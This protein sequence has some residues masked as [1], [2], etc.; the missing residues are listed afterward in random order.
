MDTNKYAVATAS[1]RFQSVWQNVNLSWEQIL[2]KLG[3]TV[4]T[5]ETLGQF[6]NMPK[7]EQDNIKDVGG[8]V[9]GYLKD[10]RR[11]TGF[12]KN[13]SL[14][15]LDADFAAEDFVGGVRMFADYTWCVYSTHKHTSEKP[16]LRLVIPLSR[17]VDCDE[18]EAIA[19]K[20]AEEIGIEQFDDTTYQSH[21]L[22][23]WPSTSIDGE[24]VFEHE[25]SKP[26][27]ADKYLEK[28]NDW[29]D[30]TSWPAS[31]RTA[32]ARISDVKK[33]EDPTTKKGVIGAFCR[34]YTIKEAIDNFL[35]DEY[36]L[37][38][39][40]DRYTYKKGSTA[41]GLVIYEDKFAYSNHATDPA[42]GRLCNAF[43][44]VRIHKFLQ[45]D[46][47]AK[48]NTPANKL[49]SFKA[50]MDFVSKDDNVK[51]NIFNEKVVEAQK[52]FVD[53]EI[54]QEDNEWVLQLKIDER[55]GY[56]N[57][58]DNLV[59]IFN[60]D[61]LL[62]NKFGYNEFT[63]RFVI[64]GE[65]PWDNEY[66]RDWSDSDEANLRH[67]IEKV[68]A[69]KGK[70]NIKDAVTIT[71][72]KNKFHP[73][74]DYLNSLKWDGNK[75]LE[76]IFCDYLGADR[77]DYV[78]FVTRKTLVAAVARIFQPGIKFDNVLTLVGKQGCGKS[79]I[80]KRLAG[81]WFSDSLTTVQGKDAFEQIQGF[82][83]IEMPELSALRKAET[84]AIKAFTAKAEDSYRA[85]YERY[86][87]TRKRQCIFLG[88]TNRYEFLKDPTGNRRFWPI[89]VNPEKA[90]KNMWEEFDEEEVGQI[91]AE[92]VSLYNNGESVYLDKEEL[93]VIV[94]EE[95]EKHFDIDPMTNSIIN[96]LN[97][98]LPDKWNEME[99]YD[100]R[101]FVNGSYDFG[102][103]KVTGKN[104]R[105]KVC[106]MEVWCE[107]YG[108]D[109][110]ECKQSDSRAIKDIIMK[111]GEWEMSKS[112]LKF[113]KAYGNQ[114]GF[115]RKGTAT[116]QK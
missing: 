92:A 40:G 33:Q 51:L 57:T 43:D 7:T 101:S 107:V 75:R 85:P 17:P 71:A 29:K 41:A 1:S 84:E 22:M 108:R 54:C 30:V 56:L 25:E 74:R 82:W 79:Q 58:I 26:L 110:S 73:V 100:R 109:K 47:D 10:G 67:Y 21:R 98:L 19:R 9:G 52:D 78:R 116:K 66:P 63:Y 12:V 44:I 16:R 81:D 89:D 96:Y 104:K 77:S 65:L 91:W 95:Q 31:N 115:V 48:P 35:Q 37:C 50:M 64:T 88:T 45:C 86:S 38:T 76:N 112:T 62:K 39:S 11:K 13:R 93:K 24:F 111:T 114:R 28:Y 23:Y 4:R 6:R 90:S 69:I 3:R 83:L 15:T 113:G 14:I 34:T 53:E 2:E 106:V 61:R 32:K 103:I 60:N 49:P 80:I 55:N 46:E 59:I 42:G 68:Y 102:E 105:E 70:D 8:F 99:I 94:E 5:N 87:T 20:V 27:H 72:L 36:E 97:M 18:Y